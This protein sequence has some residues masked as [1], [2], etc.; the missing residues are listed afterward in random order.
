MDDVKIAV[1]CCSAA[2]LLALI[3]GM[4]IKNHNEYFV[5]N[6][7]EQEDCAITETCWKKIK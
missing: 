2:L 5:K 7:Y 3:I 1:V 6:G 4:F